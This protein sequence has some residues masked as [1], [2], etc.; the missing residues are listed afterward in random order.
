[1]AVPELAQ[2]MLSI[3]A[4]AE[5]C[6]ALKG[7]PDGMRVNTGYEC[8]FSINNRHCER[9]FIYKRNIA[10]YLPLTVQ[11]IDFTA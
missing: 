4:R 9:S 11:E 10:R 2:I 1:M 7:F 8:L 3:K 5:K 6:P